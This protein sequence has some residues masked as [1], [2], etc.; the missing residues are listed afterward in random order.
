MLPGDSYVSIHSKL[1]LL[2]V[3]FAA[4]HST[5]VERVVSEAVAAYLADVDS[6][7]L[8]GPKAAARWELRPGGKG[9]K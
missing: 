7:L 4:S 5:S 1:H 6:G 3:R 8:L 2:L 9:G